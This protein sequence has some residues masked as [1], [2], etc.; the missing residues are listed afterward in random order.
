MT[1][2]KKLSAG[3]R[4]LRVI[5]DTILITVGILIAGLGLEGFLIPNN[6]IDGGVTGISLLVNELTDIPV[7]I[8]LIVI[9]IPFIIMGFKQVSRTFSI[10]AIFAIAGLALCIIIIP[11]PIVTDDKLLISVFGG[12]CLGA[13]V[14][15]AIRGGCVIDGTELLAIF[16]SKKTT[17]TVGDVILIINIFIFSAAAFILGVENAFYSV[18]T[19][20][21]ASKTVDF[22]IDGLEEYTGVTIVSDHSN[23]IQKAIIEK[24]GRG[25]TIY[26]GKRGFGK[27]GE[28]D[29]EMDIIFTVITRLEV[30]KLK[31]EINQIDK[32]AFVVQYSINDTK[33]GMIKKRPIP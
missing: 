17:A 7:S 20:L 27:R 15:F 2:T 18:L 19:Y 16:V 28:A 1:K 22:I 26:S 10:K 3:F 5:K 13:G 24:L 23:E 14:G 21:A 4:P 11:Y 6:F 12:M 9:N 30:S 33:G 29:H 8:L 31:S 32:N 25:I